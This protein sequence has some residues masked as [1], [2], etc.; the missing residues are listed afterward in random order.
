MHLKDLTTKRRMMPPWLPKAL[1][2]T[3]SAACLAWVLYGYDLREIGR[4][5]AALDWKWVAL[6]VVAD[7]AVY[8]VHGWRWKTLLSPLAKVP[9]WR[10]VQAVYIGLFAN[11]VLP[12]RTGELIRCYLL[13][14]W[15]NLRLAL[16][17]TSAAVERLI[18]GFWMVLF[19]VV[20]ASFLTLPR[21]MVD[22]V[23]VM[24]ALLVV[25]AGLMVYAVVCNGHARKLVSRSRWARTLTPLVEG[26]HA[27]A[28]WR[29]FSRTVGVSLLYLLLQVV[30]MYGLMHAYGLDLSVWAASAVVVV[31]RFGTVI[32]NAPGN[33][34]LFQASVV[35]A[36]GLFQVDPTHA[37]TFSFVCF[38]ALTLPLLIGGAVAVA[39]TGLNLKEIRRRAEASAKQAKARET[40][41]AGAT[42]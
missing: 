37:K 32:P 22:F 26:L 12:L 24:T 40:G 28:H 10:T 39:L 7:L 3:F 35:L 31:V 1:A 42:T 34:G 2:Y 25:G 20:T 29:S 38:F 30:T 23:H 8:V 4:A 18:D 41:E 13:A 21:Y 14:H 17:F 6:A 9:F 33:I 19:F 27:M 11:E 16:S 15:N 5:V 36:L